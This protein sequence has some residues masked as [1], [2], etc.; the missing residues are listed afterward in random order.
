[1]QRKVGIVNYSQPLY[2][3]SNLVC[4]Y[5]FYCEDIKKEFVTDFVF[6]MLKTSALYE[7]EL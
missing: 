1:M 4:R 3:P 7:G 6:P 5:A 2:N